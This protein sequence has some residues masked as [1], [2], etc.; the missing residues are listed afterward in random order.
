MFNEVRL[1]AGGD[2]EAGGEAAQMGVRATRERLV[3]L[4]QVIRFT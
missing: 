4:E 2:C 3:P 1:R